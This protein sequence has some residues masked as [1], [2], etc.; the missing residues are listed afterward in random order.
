MKDSKGFENGKN[1]EEKKRLP[2]KRNERERHLE[3]LG[4][5]MVLVRQLKAK[6]KKA[7]DAVD[8]CVEDLELGGYMAEAQTSMP[9]LL[10]DDDTP[11][12]RS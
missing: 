3:L 5:N 8:L 4:K 10:D 6:L 1:G 11:Q 2:F 12:A 7:Q 9:G